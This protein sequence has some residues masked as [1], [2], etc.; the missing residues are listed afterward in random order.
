MCL[1]RFASQLFFCGHVV[2]SCIEHY[3]EKQKTHSFLQKSKCFWRTCYVS[4]QA[5]DRPDDSYNEC[6]GIIIVHLRFRKEE[7][8]KI[9]IFWIIISRLFKK[10]RKTKHNYLLNKEIDHF[11]ICFSCRTLSHQNLKTFLSPCCRWKLF[12]DQFSKLKILI[13]LLLHHL[14]HLLLPFLFFLLGKASKKNRF[15]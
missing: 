6:W 15:F 4:G 12:R 1:W 9:I 8:Q 7:K 2:F 13:L 10:R 3:T 14:L 5:R 11:W